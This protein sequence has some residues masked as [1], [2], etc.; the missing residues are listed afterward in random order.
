MTFGIPK[1]IQVTFRDALLYSETAVL[2]PKSISGNLRYGIWRTHLFKQV[3]AF[4]QQ[5]AYTRGY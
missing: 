4:T 1:T 2:T 3:C 5:A